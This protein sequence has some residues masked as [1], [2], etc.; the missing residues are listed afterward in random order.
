MWIRKNKLWLICKSFHLAVILLIVLP[1]IIDINNDT[2]Q[3]VYN[4]IGLFAFFSFAYLKKKTTNKDFVE[5]K[6]E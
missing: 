2:W 5:V 4:Y 6:N 1:P 3:S